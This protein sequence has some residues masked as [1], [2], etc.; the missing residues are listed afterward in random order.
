[1]LNISIN[2]LYIN[3][4]KEINSIL[5]QNQ[6]ESINSTLI[7]IEQAKKKEKLDNLVKQNILNSISWCEEN[8]VPFY[9]DLI[10]TNIF[11]QNME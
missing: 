8:K 7:L 5:G 1:L 9:K 3:D 11:L 2:Q 6:L 4:I 10:E